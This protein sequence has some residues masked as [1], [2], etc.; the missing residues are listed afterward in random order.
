MVGLGSG[1][2]SC[3]KDINY[4]LVFNLCNTREFGDSPWSILFQPASLPR[5]KKEDMVEIR[6]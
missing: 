3:N 2:S 5:P 4:I 1:D 6:T